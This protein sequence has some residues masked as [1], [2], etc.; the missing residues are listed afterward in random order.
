[1]KLL[2]NTL[3]LLSLWFT[4]YP[5][6]ASNFHPQLVAGPYKVGFRVVQQYDRARVYKPSVDLTSGTTAAGERAR[7]IQTLIWYPAKKASGKTLHYGDYVRLAATETEFARSPAEVDQFVSAAL[8]ENY[9]DLDSNQR[10]VELAQPMLAAREA[11]EVPQQFPVL[12]Y[13]PGSSSSAYENADLCE[14][15]ASHG[16]LVLASPS[17]GVN[18]RS[19]T[20]DLEGAEAQAHDISFLVGYAATLPQADKAK[21][22]VIGYSYGGLANVLAA[23]QDDRIGAL[24]A[25]DGSVRYYSAVAQAA[26]YATPERVAVPLLYLGGKPMTVETVMSRSTQMASY[27]LLNQLKYADFYNV[28]M[29]PM[30][31]AAFQSESLRL[32]PEQRFGEYTRQEAALG[33]NWM[34]HYVLAFLNAYL[35]GEAG[36]AK[37]MRNSPKAN[38]VPAHLLSVEVHR[39]QGAPPTLPT[40]ATD[41][42]KQHY[43]HL[44]DLYRAMTKPA[45][46]FK[47]AERALISWGEPFLEQKRYAPAVEIYELVTALYPDS[48]RAAFYLALAYDKNQDKAR[49]IETYERVLSFWPDLSEA[50][51][52]IL[53]L[54]GQASSK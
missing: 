29:Y 44:A 1:M 25:L 27:S 21:L 40:L 50:K 33:Y 22:A 13:A 5:S 31:H 37:F 4:A 46:S 42:A 15:L 54:R 3:F 43:T 7:P 20:L 41:F 45:P 12:I 11:E 6:T 18:T 34:A 51:Q 17:L 26:T 14:Y 28:T 32:G 53:R 10:R 36:A 2:R 38:G 48:P 8:A 19:I 24:V 47:P 52:S 16:Y 23:A 49:A 39:G 9:A 35:K 30:E